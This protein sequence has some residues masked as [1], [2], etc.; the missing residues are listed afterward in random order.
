MNLAFSALIILFLLFPGAVLLYTYSRGPWW[1]DYASI[2]K[3]AASLPSYLDPAGG[4]AYTVFGS[5]VLHITWLA[6][7]SFFGAKI[8]FD[9]A[10]MLFLNS[11]GK[12]NKYFDGA[13][14][15]VANFTNPIAAYFISLCIIAAIVGWGSHYEVRKRAL[16]RKYPL[17][18]FNNYWHY[19]L[20]GEILE[21]PDYK[22]LRQEVGAIDG[23]YLSGILELNG[24]S[25]LYRGI[26]GDYTFDKSGQLEKITLFLAH[27]RPLDSDR[28]PDEKHEQDP[29]TRGDTRYYRIVGQFFILKYSDLK[30]INIEYITITDTDTEEFE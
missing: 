12:D 2:G 21:F 11:F 13:I 18:R 14:H 10:M 9:S 28:K 3:P 24:K 27:R 20:S 29:I 7:W 17:F 16:D 8:Y 26:V 19:L 23:T 22:A 1:L 30:T 6:I 4:I 5:F 25:Y 15:S